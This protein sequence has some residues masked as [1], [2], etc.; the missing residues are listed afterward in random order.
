MSALGILEKAPSASGSGELPP[1]ALLV[2]IKG[3]D[4]G[5]KAYVVVEEADYE[6]ASRYR[7]R[8]SN[9]YAV[10]S[11]K[12]GSGY[13]TLSM[14]REVMGLKRGDPGEVDHLNHW[15]LDNRRT[16]LRLCTHAENHQNRRQEG[17]RGSSSRFRGVS[18]FPR[19]KKNPWQ[20]HVGRKY[21]G[22]FATEEEAAKAAA[23]ARKRLMPYTLD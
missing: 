22:C 14:H 8:L 17:D 3:R 2:P 6:W 18:R 16:N 23:E 21:I 5:V 19:N 15:K 7:W 20:V 9:G 1:P 11:A 13:Y 4:G 12:D 10:R